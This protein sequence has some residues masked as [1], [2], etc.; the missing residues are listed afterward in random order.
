MLRNCCIFKWYAVQSWKNGNIH[1]T[2]CNFWLV[3]KHDNFTYRLIALALA[4]ETCSLDSEVS[5]VH[6]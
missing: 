3:S 6:T 2:R 4:K 5:Y 1:S